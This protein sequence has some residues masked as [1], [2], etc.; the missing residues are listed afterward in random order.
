M[1]TYHLLILAGVI[2]CAGGLYVWRLCSAAMG[3][4][5]GA[6]TTLILMLVFGDTVEV[7]YNDPRPVLICVGLV[8]AALAAVKLRIGAAFN[9]FLASFW[10]MAAIMLIRSDDMDQ[11][12][13]LLLL[14]AVLA[15][16]IAWLSYRFARV[17]FLIQSAFSGAVVACLGIYCTAHDG[18]LLESVLYMLLGDER[19]IQELGLWLGGLF[20]VGGA[21]QWPA[22]THEEWT[23][24]ALVKKQIGALRAGR[25]GEYTKLPRTGKTG[26]EKDWLLLLAPAAAFFLMPLA[27]EQGLA[28]LG[29]WSSNTYTVMMVL[30]ELCE[31]AAIAAQVYSVLRKSARFNVLF[32]LICALGYELNGVSSFPY[33]GIWPILVWTA[34]GALLWGVMYAL[35]RL[36]RHDGAKP[37][38]M[39]AAGLFLHWY[40]VDWLA[41]LDL[42][43]YFPWY[44]LV[45]AAAALGT[46]YWVFRRADVNVFVP[47]SAYGPTP[48]EPPAAVG[49]KRRL[50]NIL[51]AAMAGCG[52]VLLLG[53]FIH[54][55]PVYYDYGN[56]YGYDLN[57]YLSSDSYNYGD[58]GLGGFDMGDFDLGDFG[59]G[60]FDMGSLGD[61]GGYSD[62]GDY[63]NYGGYDDYGDYSDYSGYG[64]YD[65]YSGYSDY[66]DSSG[67]GADL[68]QY[69]SGLGEL[70]SGFGAGSAEAQNGSDFAVPVPA[71]EPPA[72]TLPP[73]QVEAP[74][75]TETPAWTQTPQTPAWTET[76]VWTEVPATPAPVVETGGESAA[77]T[78]V[79]LTTSVLNVRE[80]ANTDCEVLGVAESGTI[81]TP[82]SVGD[83]WCAVQ[84][85]DRTAYVS[86]DYVYQTTLEAIA[87]GEVG[88]ICAT[89]ALNVRSGPGTNYEVV[90][91]L[92]DGQRVVYVGQ[93]DGWYEI[94]IHKGEHAYVSTEYALPDAVLQG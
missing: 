48:V 32:C 1:N 28:R 33:Y 59:L 65:D 35:A 89:T 9:A 76:P 54:S 14:A 27:Y 81:L 2:L 74:A 41:M 70:F 62:Y 46:L 58:F 12:K 53:H 64:G 83:A 36:I 30:T 77:E 87:R 51:L 84:L 49:G 29:W 43:F 56:D 47:G 69:L 22:L 11:L 91:G 82:V 3:F 71:T 73:V 68:G 6:F 19:M 26:L 15:A 93:Q 88:V 92:D 42:W 63:S 8:C 10:V 67:S 25:Q 21:I 55:A 17:S 44:H 23:A 16:G 79:L 78:A 86:S 60:G 61:L 40:A 13:G 24:E 72:Q 80:Q 7:L 37:L 45:G 31:G 5:W 90:W 18:E 94:I 34:R 85:G 38:A 75:W 20:L 52:A 66:G 57:G 50:E 39:L 4:V